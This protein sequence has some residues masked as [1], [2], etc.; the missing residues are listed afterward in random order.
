M[1]GANQRVRVAMIGCGGRGHFLTS[2]FAGLDQVE[3]AAICDPDTAQMERLAADLLEREIDLSR[4]DRI[5]DYRAVYDRADID[6]V[7]IASPNHWHALHAIQAMEAGKHVYVEKPVT[8]TVFEGRQ[9][10]AAARTYGRAIQAGYQNRSDPGPIEGIRFVREGNLGAIQSVRVV[11]YRNRAG[12]GKRATPLTPPETVDHHLWL[13]PAEDL[14]ILRPRY[15]YDWHWVWNTGDGDIGNQ[16][17]HEIDLA[18]WVLGDGPLPAEIRSFGNRFAWDD[19]GETPNQIAAW[20]E[21]GG[22]PVIIEVN[23]LTVS[24]D[25]DASPVRNEIRVGIVV[26]C[27][28]GELRGGRGGMYAVGED[29]KTRTHKFPGDGGGTHQQNFIDAVRAGSGAGLHAPIHLAERSAT[30]EQLANIAY[31]IGADAEPGELEAVIGDN[32]GL[33]Q[34]VDDQARQLKVWGID[35][36]V[37]HMGRSLSLDPATAAI[38]TPDVDPRL[39]HPPGRAE[40]VVPALA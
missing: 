2:Q 14:P 24:P 31:R 37:Y 17:P 36:P 38:R 26:R 32:A 30:I 18:N 16:C 29:G 1:L 13:G 27:E 20:Y 7:M 33:R 40:F 21:Q 22:V 6:A 23:N 5:R 35:A 11:C 12:I 15:H 3:I 4:A 28:G 34:I 25:V 39:A 10:V 19:A 8:H 9:L